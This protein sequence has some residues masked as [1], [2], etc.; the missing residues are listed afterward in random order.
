MLL[1][2]TQHNQMPHPAQQIVKTPQLHPILRRQQIQQLTRQ[3]TLLTSLKM[4][5]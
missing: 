4:P 5:A 2:Q 1:L 3:L